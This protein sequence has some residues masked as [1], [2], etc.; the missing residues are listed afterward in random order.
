[1]LLIL[2][3]SDLMSQHTEIKYLSGK[4]F[5]DAV[6]W[7]FFCTAGRNSGKWT[8][9][10]VPSC[11]E[12]EGFGTLNYG[13]DKE[14]SN[15]TGIYRTN[16]SILPNWKGK[17]I[18]I[19]FEGAMTDAIV[20]VN[21]KQVGNK[22]Q[23]AFYRFKYEITDFVS[24]F[25]ENSL[26]VIVDKMS[27]NE[28]VNKAERFC[29]FWVFGGLFRPVYLE[30]QPLKYIEYVSINAQHDGGFG[31]DVFMDKPYDK[32]SLKV[33][34]FDKSNNL[35]NQLETKVDK[36][37]CKKLSLTGKFLDIKQWTD[38]SPVL[39][40]AE[41]TVSR[42]GKLLHKVNEKI[43]FR[44]IEVKEKEG[45]FIN[46]KK[47]RFKGINRHSH[48]P[49][50]GRTTCKALSIDDVNLIKD[51]NMNA[52][53]M[54]HYPPDKHFLEVCD[55]LGLYV[56]NE[57]CSWQYPPY[58]TEV[59][60]KLVKE[61]VTR[62]L[63][64]PSIIFW[65][66][67]NE[68]GFNFEL[69]PLFS[70]YDLQKRPVL[71]PIEKHDG[72]NTVHYQKYNAGIGNMFNGR[73]IF[74]PTENMHGL[75][76][77]GHGAGLSDF[78]ESAL[79]KHQS[80]GMFLWDFADQAVLRD[81]GCLDT[82]KD[83]GADGIVG[84]YR[85]KEGSF[86]TVK[87]IWSPVQLEHRF[88]TPFWDGTIKIDNYYNFTNTNECSFYYNLV[89]FN[90]FDIT[91]KDSINGEL[92]SPD[93]EP[94][95][96]KRVFLNLPKEWKNYDFLYIT[97]KNKFNN[98]LFTWSYEINGADKWRKRN[99]PSVSC[100][101][102]CNEDDSCWI[103]SNSRNKVFINKTTGLLDKVY[104]KDSLLPLRNGPILITDKILTCNSIKKIGDRKI[105]VEY[106]GQG[107]V[108]KFNWTMLDNG[109]LE[110]DYEYF[111]GDEVDMAG[112]T[113]SYPEKDINGVTLLSNGPYR[114]YNNRR[115][116]GTVSM[117][118][119]T[120][121]DT[122][123][124][125]TWIYPEFKGYYSSFYAIKFKT[126]I[127]FEIYT[128]TDDIYLHLFTP[129]AQKLYNETSNFTLCKYPKGNISFMNV[130][131]S[132]GTKFHKASAYGPKSQTVFYSG[133]GENNYPCGKLY[134]KFY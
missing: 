43:G 99:L 101:I 105:L 25:K 38:E 81:N 35:K 88:L 95:A 69:D 49:T 5:D 60:S 96:S 36:S 30:V 4:G 40:T 14:K 124:G 66:N 89:R 56:I 45:I 10:P 103:W 85:E 50:T 104:L 58:D 133:G 106:S 91:K 13:F 111:S 37:K 80:A 19:V 57:L 27:S 29:D 33:R 131:P 21:G 2:Y 122:R 28:T 1:M 47:I 114:V 32:L 121:N 24:F 46:G 41:I 102:S 20:K 52:V 132:V 53:R 68:G 70:Q 92:C 54:S 31:I 107:M 97:V 18:F 51:M 120:Y 134:F 119:K 39:Y 79:S 6:E 26:E 127:P 12:M 64:H 129:K 62:D 48:W 77:G 76:D 71:H 34:I 130:I 7:N 72:I 16:F 126:S 115:E 116:G 8:K 90:G 22:H 100:E 123:T 67:G 75:Y 118:N 11:W 112:I 98:E 93:I 87:Q 83:H 109:V 108:L 82:D 44:T 117:W 65:A 9:I 63:N 110:L 128:D 73:D 94:G 23:G 125:E 86:Y 3:V 42:N 74:M 55:S 61:M 15:E 78:W 17:R 84:P 113:F 59:G